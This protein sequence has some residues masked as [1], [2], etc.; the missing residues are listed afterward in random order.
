MKS[1]NMY[2]IVH[3]MAKGLFVNVIYKEK[4]LDIQL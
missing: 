1:R 2:F 3:T 4:I